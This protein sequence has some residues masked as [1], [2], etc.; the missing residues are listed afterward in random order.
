[1]KAII[2]QK[3]KQNLQCGYNGN[4]IVFYLDNNKVT[5]ISVTY[6]KGD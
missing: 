3:A 2:L 6:F 1:M 5:G 4:E